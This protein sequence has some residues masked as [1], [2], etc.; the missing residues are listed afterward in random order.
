MRSVWKIVVATLT[1]MPRDQEWRSV[2]LMVNR[3][4]LSAQHGNKSRASQHD[5]RN[6]R[7]CPNHRRWPTTVPAGPNRD[8]LGTLADSMGRVLEA[9]IAILL[10]IGNARISLAERY[11]AAAR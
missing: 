5:T 8:D 10:P 3:R 6:R 9:R 2:D 11:R 1:Q 7:V 4:R